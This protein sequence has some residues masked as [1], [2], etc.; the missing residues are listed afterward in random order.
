MFHQW[1]E[2]GTYYIIW[3]NEATY[4]YN[5]SIHT[6]IGFSPAELMFGRKCRIPLDIMFGIDKNG[7]SNDNSVTQFKKNLEH[8]RSGK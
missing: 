3:S 8:I 7:V 4:A 1:K 2:I 5:T 6:S